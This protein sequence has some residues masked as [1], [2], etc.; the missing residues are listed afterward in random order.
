MDDFNTQ[1]AVLNDSLSKLS[2]INS[3]LGNTSV[4][5]DAVQK[6]LKKDPQKIFHIIDLGCGA[7]DNLRAIAAWC[8]ENNRVVKLTGIDG[9]D[10]ILS[11]AKQQKSDAKICC[12]QAD[13]FRC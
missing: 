2:L 4:T 5:L 7:G 9:N 8:F 3:M 10:H 11:Y 6:V 12:K 1:G 13:I